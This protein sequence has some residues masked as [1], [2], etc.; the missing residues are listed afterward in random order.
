MIQDSSRNTQCS[1]QTEASCSEIT[2]TAVLYLGPLADAGDCKVPLGRELGCSLGVAS[3]E[4]RILCSLLS[5]P[6]QLASFTSP[7]FLLS[8]SRVHVQY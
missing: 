6:R 7:V 3:L 1:L 5:V 4:N 8:T 2:W